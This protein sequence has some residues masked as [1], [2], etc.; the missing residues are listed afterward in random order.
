MF[1]EAKL[2][3]TRLEKNDGLPPEEIETRGNAE[4][5][6]HFLVHRIKAPRAL[7][8]RL[9][10]RRGVEQ[11]VARLN[12][13]RLH[14]R[15]LADFFRAFFHRGDSGFVLVAREHGPWRCTAIGHRNARAHLGVLGDAQRVFCIDKLVA[16][17]RAGASD[18]QLRIT[19][20]RVRKH[21]RCAFGAIECCTGR[22]HAAHRQKQL[23][24]QDE[25]IHALLI[26]DFAGERFEVVHV[27]V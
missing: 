1:D 7:F 17:A 24:L 23:A 22:F 13:N 20:G 6:E 16:T 15:H 4:K 18:S 12:G 11:E 25:L 27:D 3:L 2:V 26:E 9:A 21:F 5:F 19:S 8:D 14:A 10:L